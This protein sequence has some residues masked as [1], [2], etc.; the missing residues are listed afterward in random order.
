MNV[1]KIDKYIFITVLF[2]IAVA[3]I[4]SSV[5]NLWGKDY[6]ILLGGILTFS[7]AFMAVF[8]YDKE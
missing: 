2:F 7:L 5:G 6:G 1:D 4:G 3:M 8:Y